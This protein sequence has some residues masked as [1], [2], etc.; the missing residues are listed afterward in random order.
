MVNKCA[1]LLLVSLV[2]F[3]GGSN[4]AHATVVSAGCLTSLNTAAGPNVTGSSTCNAFDPLLGTL[5]GVSVHYSAGVAVSVRNDTGF[6]L[7]TD[8]SGEFDFAPF[9]F[10]SATERTGILSTH[11]GVPAGQTGG[12]AAV[13]QFSVDVSTI[14]NAFAFFTGPAGEQF[15][16]SEQITKYH[17]DV[18][19]LSSNWVLESMT[20]N[21]AVNIDYTYTANV[22]PPAGAPEPGAFALAALG[23]AV[24]GF[25]RR[26]RA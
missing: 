25:S 1:A 21:V 2:A 10:S 20:G 23:L 11:H 3:A 17:M 24:L 5:T 14:P 15:T 19:A 9:P 4:S 7:V 22:V 18:T 16:L 26:N 13:T 12:A 6:G 8:V